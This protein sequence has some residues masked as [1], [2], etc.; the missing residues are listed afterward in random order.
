MQENHLL[1]KG[2]ALNA[3]TP[4]TMF[5]A[6]FD[7]DIIDLLVLETNR[8]RLVLNR[9]NMCAVTV[10]DMRVFIGI[11]LYMTI[12]ELP[13]RR[14]YWSPGTRQALIADAMTCNRFE[15][16]LSVL[17]VNDNELSKER[18]QPG[19]DRLHKVRP[20]IDQL[21]M[22]FLN[23]AHREVCIA[24]DEQIIPFKGRHSLKVYMMKKP[25]KWGY[26]VWV[27]AGQSGYVHKFIFAGDNL[28]TLNNTDIVA[29][30]GKAGQVVMALSEDQPADS[31]V[32]FDNYFSSPDL[33]WELKKKKL[34]ATCT[35]RSNRSR[36]CP[37]LCQKDLKKGGRGSFD[38]RLDEDKSVMVCEW[39]DNKVVM[40]A[41][42]VHGVHPTHVVKRYDRKAKRHIEVPCPGLIKRY[43]ENM[44]GVDKC[45]MLLAL[46]RNTL[47]SRKW[48][49][50]IMF[51]LIDL[52][53]VNSWLLYKASKPECSLPLAFF[54]FQVAQSLIVSSKAALPLQPMISTTINVSKSRKDVNVDAR[55]DRVDH[56]PKRMNT[57]N[58]QRCK[59]ETCKRKSMFI[60]RKCSVY[61]CLTGKDE[62]EDCFYRFHCK[63]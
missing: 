49:K 47:K 9:T 20:L 6:H 53:I 36:K 3:T 19:F 56:L 54:K 11:I 23:C 61:L 27:H 57:K 7:D 63:Q 50:R 22:N 38:H 48:Y 41:S 4:L 52:C 34:N 12:V 17:H 21:N 16:I 26:K 32:F 40:V 8:Q 43:N 18:G 10:E 1:P 15:E 5:T 33:L 62:E 39:Y 42:N 2:P 37:V 31:Y 13:F 46:Y 45:D 25:T 29:G 55:Y 51:H 28:S 35:I 60:C 14:M 58:A 59:L 30:I 24:I 44:G